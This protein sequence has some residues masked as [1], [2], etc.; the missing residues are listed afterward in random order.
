MIILSWNCRGVAAAERASELKNLCNIKSNNDLDW[1]CCFVYGNP[2]FKHRRRIWQVLSESKD[3]VD[4]PSCF[5]GDFNNILNQDEKVGKYPKPP[6][7][8][9]EF[10]D[11]VNK[12]NLM[13]LELKGSKSLGSAT[14][15]M[16]S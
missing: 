4:E 9:E 15:E 10:R 2:I 8:I 13:D 11:L 14:Q 5:I 7:Q 16:V 6:I 3:M 1:K 12:K